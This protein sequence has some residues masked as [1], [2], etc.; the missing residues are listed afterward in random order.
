[1]ERTSPMIA[2]TEALQDDLARMR[3]GL[4]DLEPHTA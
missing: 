3:R 1:M 2:E 4:A